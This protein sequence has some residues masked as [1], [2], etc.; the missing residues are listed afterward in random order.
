M[1]PFRIN[2][3][4]KKDP[5]KKYDFFIHILMTVNLT[6]NVHS[7]TTI[8]ITHPFSQSPSPVDGTER[9]LGLKY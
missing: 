1:K 3:W 9:S 6:K 5:T 4:T 8:I 7:I 2:G